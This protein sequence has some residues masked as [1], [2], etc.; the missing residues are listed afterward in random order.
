[1]SEI[2]QK[3]IL[4]F[5]IDLVI[6]G[7]ISGIIRSIL[8]TIFIAK[9]YTY[10]GI[11][12]EFNFEFSLIVY[13]IYFIAFDIMNQGKTFGKYLF[14]N[15]VVFTDKEPT[16]LDL[17]KRSLLKVVSIMIL[18]ISILL[19]LFYNVFTIQDHFSGSKV[20]TE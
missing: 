1:M 9:T 2:Q 18:P 10:I 6:A 7:I 15:K 13:V 3:R 8:S 16:K 17:I 20:I 12:F 14:N 4:A 5:I 11:N 19:Y